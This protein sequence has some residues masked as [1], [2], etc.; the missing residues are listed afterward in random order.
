MYSTVV[1]SRQFC[2]SAGAFYMPLNLMLF[3]LYLLQVY[4]FYFIVNVLV[5]VKTIYMYIHIYMITHN[6][7]NRA[8][9]FISC[10]LS[11]VY[12]TAMLSD[13]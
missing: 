6:T 8:T 5:K 11:L 3:A 1:A 4:W 2:A 7:L 10:H 13:K 9:M 12:Y